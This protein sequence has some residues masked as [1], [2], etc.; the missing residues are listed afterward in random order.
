MAAAQTMPFTASGLQWK[1]TDYRPESL[2]P[3]HRRLL[4]NSK[5][6][7]LL[8]ESQTDT[9][10]FTVEQWLDCSIC[11]LRNDD[12]IKSGERYFTPAPTPQWLTD[13]AAEV[14]ESKWLGLSDE[15]RASLLQTTVKK[16][17][18]PPVFAFRC[19][20]MVPPEEMK[21][22][23]K[24]VADLWKLWTFPKSTA[25][26]TLDTEELT[27]EQYREKFPIS[28]SY[29]VEIRQDHKK[30][31]SAV[32]FNDSDAYDGLPVYGAKGEKALK[33]YQQFLQGLDLINQVS[34]TST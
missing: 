6:A 28:N 19:T 16:S 7:K 12:I 31:A 8:E 3:P 15:K 30:W 1:K 27:F 34:I 32:V 11:D 9:V 33:A 2:P 5:L 18:D 21:Q 25:K 13:Y 23:E 24:Q 20:E 29:H 17:F 14:E 4:D 26:R 10:E 22:R